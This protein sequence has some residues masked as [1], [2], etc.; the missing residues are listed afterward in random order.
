MLAGL[1]AAAAL[2]AQQD[3]QVVGIVGVAIG[4]ARAARSS[5]VQERL[6]AFLDRFQAREQIDGC[7]TCQ[8][9]MILYESIL[10]CCLA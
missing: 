3:R 6:V 1:E 10:A 8:R 2:A 7:S 5:I 4:Q 9:V